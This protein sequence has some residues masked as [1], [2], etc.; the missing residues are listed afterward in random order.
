MSGATFAIP[1]WA[2][3]AAI[4]IGGIQGAAY[5][6]GFRE[7]RIDLFGVAVIGVATGLGGGVLR[8]IALSTQL[9]A[10]RSDGYIP[11]AVAAALIGMLLA[12]VFT[13][14]DTAITVL[15]ALTLGLFGAIGTSKALAY[16]LPEIPAAFVGVLA[17]VGGGVLRDILLNMPITVMH[18]GSF[19]AVAAGIGTV[20]LVVLHDLDVPVF[21][22]ASV[23]AAV[24][25]AVRLLAVAFGWSLP[26]QRTLELSRANVGFGLLRRRQI[27]PREYVDTATGTITTYKVVPRGDGGE[28][29]AG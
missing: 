17:A 3:Y 5:A 19:Y 22:A 18:V 2:E 4:A 1:V 15:D 16:G 24:T 6:T 23:S 13:R 8:D 21:V 9:V 11:A 7:R 27:A 25:F 20:T 26:E 29:P 14:F 28:P 10:L 12:S